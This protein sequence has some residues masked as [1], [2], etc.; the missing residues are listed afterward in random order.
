M[1]DN[2]LA[3]LGALIGG[4]IGFLACWWFERHG[5][6]AMVLPGGL[7]GLGAGIVRNRS[8]WVAIVCGLLAAALGVWTEFHFWPFKADKSF[9]FFIT[10]L[11]DLDAVTLLMIAAGGFIG[12]WCPFRRLQRAGNETGKREG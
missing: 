11:T 7:L 2:L 6:Y 3:L 9:K 5:F 1:K 12:F 4:T 10:H 8:I